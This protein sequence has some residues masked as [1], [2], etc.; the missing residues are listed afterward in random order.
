M[1]IKE[2]L[3]AFFIGGSI[4]LSPISV[5]AGFQFLKTSLVDI[6]KNPV[7]FYEK[8]VE[9]KAYFYKEDNIWVKSLP[10]SENYFGVFVTKPRGDIL[11][12]YGEYFGFIFVPKEMKSK[13]R[14]LKGGD[15]ITIRGKCFN[16][17][18]LSIDGPGIEAADILSGWGE[19]TKPLK[20]F[21]EDDMQEI[22]S[23]I[24]DKKSAPS[25]SGPLPAV[26]PAGIE[27]SGKY[28][29]FLNGKEYEGLTVGDEYVFE[30]I[31][32]RIEKE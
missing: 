3:L 14:L 2:C 21:S 24:Q 13:I 25:S 20:A 16:F 9:V 10:H 4:C 1:K 7:D 23:F 17:I 19:H 28:H 27:S 18:S 32:F 29:L 15:E 31:R 11:P 6:E 5:F 8:N 22:A 12:A 30:G 26:S